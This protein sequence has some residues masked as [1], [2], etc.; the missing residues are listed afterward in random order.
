VSELPAVKLK[1]CG[2]IPSKGKRFFLF[3]RLSKLVLGPNQPFD[4]HKD[5]S[6]QVKQLRHKA[7]QSAALA[8]SLRTTGPLPPF[9]TYA[10]TGST[11]TLYPNF[12]FV[13]YLQ[14]KTVDLMW[15]VIWDVGR[16]NYTYT[17]MTST[18]FNNARSV[19]HSTHKYMLTSLCKVPPNTL[20][21]IEDRL[22]WPRE[23]YGLS[24]SVKSGRK[25][26]SSVWSRSNIY[27]RNSWA[28]CCW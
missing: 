2:S 16:C 3:S 14:L 19:T 8:P 5:L 7:D 17:N 11:Q 28:S 4:G 9:P 26:S 12:N 6:S 21:T 13:K 22:L 18:I 15:W 24:L 20:V 23:M 27:R 10:S 25:W 1:T